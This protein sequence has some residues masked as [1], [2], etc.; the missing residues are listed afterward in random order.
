MPKYR[1]K[2]IQSLNIFEA[3]EEVLSLDSEISIH[4]KLYYQNDA[5][6]IDDA[7]YDRLRRRLEG[8]VQR[9]PELTKI[10]PT[11]RRVGTAPSPSF[12]SLLAIVHADCHHRWLIENDAL[13]FNI[14][15]RIFCAEI[16]R[17]IV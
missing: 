2:L 5:P 4:D 6:E 3:E 9:F 8:L 10:S 17:Q 12:S 13:I 15:Q 1:D 11:L 7:S 16:N 14:N